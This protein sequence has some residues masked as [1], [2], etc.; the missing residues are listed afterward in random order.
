MANRRSGAG[1]ICRSVHI[2]QLLDGA[3]KS[4]CRLRA[5]NAPE[6]R[7]RQ[8][9]GDPLTAH[10][11][12]A[13]I[14]PAVDGVRRGFAGVKSNGANGGAGAASSL[15]TAVQGSTTG[16]LTLIQN[17]V[18][19]A[20]GS[21]DT[22]TPGAGGVGLFDP[23]RVRHQ[24]EPGHGLSHRDR[25]R[26]R[27]RGRRQRRKRRRRERLRLRR[28][29]N[30]RRG[31]GYSAAGGRER[32]LW[33]QRRQRR[34][35][36]RLEPGDQSREPG[37]HRHDDR[38]CGRAG[39]NGDRRQWRLEHRRNGRRSGQRLVDA[40]LYGFVCELAVRSCLG[41]RRQWRRRFRSG[42]D[43]RQWRDGRR[44]GLADIHCRRRAGYGRSHPIGRRRRRRNER[45]QWGRRR[46]TRSWSP[47]RQ[48]RIL[49]SAARPLAHSTCSNP[50]LAAL[51]G[52]AIPARPAS[53]AMASQF[54]WSR[55]TPPVRSRDCRRRMAGLAAAR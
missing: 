11:A 12:I 5:R 23:H 34:G 44:R 46:R 53:P 19:G 22:G 52:A 39:A 42:L 47:V 15:D 29:L 7:A 38:R 43:R 32:R 20:G 27:K 45:R 17:A 16:S 3:G 31:Q 41:R 54:L 13:D 9:L 18:G 37:R 1:S 2:Q 40:R 48:R 6:T 14:C 36:R 24:R 55:T 25:R 33:I 35:R 10:L 30:W 26:R 8:L 21:S 49:R 50:R 4:F 51:P 28:L